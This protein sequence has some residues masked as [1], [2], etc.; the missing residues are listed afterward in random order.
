MVYTQQA[1]F[2]AMTVSSLY[3]A[4]KTSFTFVRTLNYIISILFL[5]TKM[6]E[7]IPHSFSLCPGIS[8]P[9][10]CKMYT[11]I[12]KMSDFFNH[13]TTC[14]HLYSYIMFHEVWGI[15]KQVFEYIQH[16]FF[17]FMVFLQRNLVEVQFPL[18]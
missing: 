10:L 17:W 4:K 1:I 6:F 13:N 3:Q 12:F 2:W 15:K 5:S 14:P 7:N 9:L 8:I 16:H 11:F 18:K